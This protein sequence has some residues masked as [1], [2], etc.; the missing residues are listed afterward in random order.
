VEQIY[1]SL[2]LSPALNLAFLNLIA[3]GGTVT[4]YGGVVSISTSTRYTALNPSDPSVNPVSPADRQLVSLGVNASLLTCTNSN[5]LVFPFTSSQ[6]IQYISIWDSAAPAGTTQGDLISY[7]LL[8]EP[9]EVVSGQSF[10]IH[11]QTLTIQA[12]VG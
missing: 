11:I 3:G 1:L 6:T 8:A 5:Q 7:F 10:T 9:I 4:T 2:M 12:T